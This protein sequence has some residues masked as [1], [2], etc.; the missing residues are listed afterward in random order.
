LE[1]T[2]GSEENELSEG[3]FVKHAAL[4]NPAT[5]LGMHF[6]PVPGA[7]VGLKHEGSVGF[8]HRPLGSVDGLTERSTRYLRIKPLHNRPRATPSFLA[9]INRAKEVLHLEPLLLA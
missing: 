9:N 5:I 2:N 7:S 3:S 4:V 1:G 6:I 8:E